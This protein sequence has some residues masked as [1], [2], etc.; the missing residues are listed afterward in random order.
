MA[1]VRRLGNLHHTRLPDR[2]ITKYQE[3]RKRVVCHTRMTEM[4][5]GKRGNREMVRTGMTMIPRR[6]MKERRR[7]G[8]KKRRRKKERKR[9]KRLRIQVVYGGGP[10]LS[11]CLT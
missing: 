11:R 9:A 6:I 3:L 8:K 7:K 5:I 2:H 4:I 10:L 1:I